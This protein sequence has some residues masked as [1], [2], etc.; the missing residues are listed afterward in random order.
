MSILDEKGRLFGKVNLLDLVVLLA[1]LAVAGR[2]GYERW[3][4]Q[5]AAPVGEDVPLKV[6]MRFAAV[7]DPTL[8]WVKVGDKIYD[9]KS[10][11]FMG[12]VTEVRHE[13]AIVVTTDDDGRTYE[14]ASKNRFD[15]YVT[16]AGSGRISPNAVTMSGL[17]VKIGRVNY[18]KTAYWA[19]YGSTWDI[20]TD[21]KK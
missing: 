5:Q 4:G 20:I 6:V 13:P 10:N 3:Q 11:T 15:F 7:A 16:V 8:K 2:F 17:E 14:Q 9:S 18:V 19:G 1:V 12:E 21:S